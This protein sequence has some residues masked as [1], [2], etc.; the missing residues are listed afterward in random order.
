[1]KKPEPQVLK[2]LAATV[3]NNP[4]LLEWLRT[5]REDELRRLPYAVDHT[6]IYQGRCQMVNEVL[7]FLS[8]APDLA[9]KP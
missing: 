5:V 1:M 6:A 2:A 8:Q 9:A 3:V 4:A 7:D